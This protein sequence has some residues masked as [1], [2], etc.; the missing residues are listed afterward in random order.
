MEHLVLGDDFEVKYLRI[1]LEGLEVEVI[2]V[3]QR[4][5]S[6]EGLLV[7]VALLHPFNLDLDRVLAV[8]EECAG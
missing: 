4:I 1:E 2:N 6:L 7:P 3:G 8:C 5:R